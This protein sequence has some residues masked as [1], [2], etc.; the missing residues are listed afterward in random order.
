[1]AFGVTCNGSIVYSENM[2]LEVFNNAAVV[3]P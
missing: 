3:M 1:M 2:E